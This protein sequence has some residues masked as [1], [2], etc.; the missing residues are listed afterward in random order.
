MLINAAQNSGIDPNVDHF[1]SIKID[2]H[3]EAMI[4]I[5]DQCHDF[6]RHWSALGIDRGS[7]VNRKGTSPGIAMFFKSYW[8][9]FNREAIPGEK[10]L[11]S[12]LTNSISCTF[13]WISVQTHENWAA[14]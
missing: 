8:S 11:A 6:D 9:K 3:S 5:L 12:E 2:R 1:Q 4:G 10:N 7:L 14:Y 13:D